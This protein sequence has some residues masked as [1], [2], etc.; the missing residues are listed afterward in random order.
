MVFFKMSLATW[1]I[2]RDPPPL[3]GFWPLLEGV[4][5][6]ANVVIAAQLGGGYVGGKKLHH[7]AGLFLRATSLAHVLSGLPA[8]TVWTHN[9]LLPARL[10]PA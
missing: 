4:V 6:P 8:R 2:M 7:D 10:G 1:P 9:D 5:A 3:R